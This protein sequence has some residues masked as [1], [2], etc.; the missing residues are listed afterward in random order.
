MISKSR[1]IIG[2]ILC[3]I[4]CTI[5]VLA[6]KYKDE[7]FKNEVTII[8]PN[9]CIEKYVNQKLITKECTEGRILLEKQKNGENMEP[10]AWKLPNLSQMNLT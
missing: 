7:W 6:I 8:Y 4:I 10:Y 2:I 9:R 3:I 1:I 5:F